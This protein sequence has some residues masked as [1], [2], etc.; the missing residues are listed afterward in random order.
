MAN[1]PGILRGSRLDV[2]FSFSLHMSELEI[3]LAVTR[4]IW[5]LHDY[6]LFL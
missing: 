3:R 5:K 2:F 1:L 6:R 4:T